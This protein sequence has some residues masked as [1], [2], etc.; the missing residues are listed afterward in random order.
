VSVRIVWISFGALPCRKKSWWQLASRFCWNRARLWHFSELVSL[1]VGLRTYQ[2]PGNFFLLKWTHNREF[3]CSSPLFL[4]YKNINVIL[5]KIYEHFASTVVTLVSVICCH[6]SVIQL[7]WPLCHSSAVTFLFFICYHFSVT[8]LLSPFC[9]SSGITFLSLIS[10]KK[11]TR[12][13][14]CWITLC[15]FNDASSKTGL[16]PNY[17]FGLGTQLCLQDLKIFAVQYVCL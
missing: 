17:Y 15:L 1:L 8:H 16:L 4:F 14:K 6:L 11:K 2:H 10:D 5:L 3:I 12:N 9:F 7:L 13:Q